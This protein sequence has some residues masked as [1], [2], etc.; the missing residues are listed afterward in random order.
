MLVL[1]HDDVRQVLDGQEARVLDAVREA[2][3]L[4]AGGR[5]S[6]PH[7]VFLRFPGKERERI[8]G[9]PAYLDAA[10]ATAGIKWVASF[11][12]NHE[13]ALPR[14]SAVVMT[15]SA[16]TGRPEAVIEGSVISARRTGASAALAA[17]LLANPATPDRAVSLIGC[18]LIQFEVLRF[19][20]L[21][22]PQVAEVTLF[23]RDDTRAADFAGRCTRAWPDLTVR[24]ARDAAEALAAHRLVSL[25]TTAV[26][27]HLDTRGCR[28]GTLLLHVSLRDL[29][30]EAILAARNVVDDTDHVCRERTS[31]HL[32]EQLA[33]HR[34]FIHDEIGNLLRAPENDVRRD[35]DRV[36]VFSPFGLGVLDLAL[37]RL[38]QDDAAKAGLG[39]PV[40]DFLP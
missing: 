12:A 39:V 37:A 18:G 13:R 7:S 34:G 17:G 2:Y 40:P 29:T 6:L 38:V 32:A 20:R 9:L 25:A 4:H 26:R 24:H 5:T 3:L 33:G 14:A 30:P 23:D 8:I 21:T 28:P 31:V 27:P 36:T 15:N 35:P 1:T 11:P 16:E 10:T 22:C 19:L